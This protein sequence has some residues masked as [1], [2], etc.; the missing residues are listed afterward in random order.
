[1]PTK[2]IEIFP[3][4]DFT[5]PKE[6]EKEFVPFRGNQDYFNEIDPIQMQQLNRMIQDLFTETNFLKNKLKLTQV[7]LISVLLLLVVNTLL[8]FYF[9]KNSNVNDL[10]EENAITTPYETNEPEV[11]TET[12]TEEDVNDKPLENRSSVEVQKEGSIKEPTVTTNVQNTKSNPSP[13]LKD[14]TKSNVHSD[15]VEQ[16]KNVATDASKSKTQNDSLKK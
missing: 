5:F 3:P 6:E 15:K 10:K 16:Q 12:K 11:V 13:K 14:L 1:M 8:L 9:I 2:I 7:L 4:D